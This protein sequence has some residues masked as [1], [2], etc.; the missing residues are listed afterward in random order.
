MLIQPLQKVQSLHRFEYSNGQS[1]TKIRPLF[2]NDTPCL[3]LPVE[4]WGVYCEYFS[5][6]LAFYNGTAVHE[7]ES[8]NWTW[9]K[10]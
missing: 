5:E 3:A 10:Y 4:L 1:R 6:K 2:Q 7:A 8:R 9:D